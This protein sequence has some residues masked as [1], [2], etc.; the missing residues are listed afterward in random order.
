CVSL[1]F[2]SS[3]SNTFTASGLYCTISIV[4]F[5]LSSCSFP[6]P[7]IIVAAAIIPATSEV[8]TTFLF[9]LMKNILLPELL[10]FY[11]NYSILIFTVKPT[12]FNKETML[13]LYTRKHQFKMIYICKY[14]TIFFKIA[15]YFPLIGLY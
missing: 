12:F 3:A 2:C 6:Q 8:M 4:T 10:L 5:P 9:F 1:N 15:S 13:T 14:K 11:Y 7:L